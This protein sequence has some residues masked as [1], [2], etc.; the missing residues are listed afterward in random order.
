[1]ELG[2]APAEADSLLIDAEGDSAEELLAH[3]LRLARSGA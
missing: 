3:A 1:M 2:Y